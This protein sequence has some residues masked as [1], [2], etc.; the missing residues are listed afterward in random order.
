[1]YVCEPCVNLTLME[2]SDTLEWKL[3]NCFKQLLDARDWTQVLCW[4]ISSTPQFAFVELGYRAA[5][6]LF[7]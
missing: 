2:A 3:I 1:M 5:F 7:L 6:R 4:A